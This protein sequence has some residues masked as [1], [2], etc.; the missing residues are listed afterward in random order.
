MRQISHSERERRGREEEREAVTI[1]LVQDSSP[2]KNLS[3]A[4]TRVK[5]S[6]HVNVC[7][8]HSRRA[9]LSLSLS[10]CT[11]DTDREQERVRLLSLFSGDRLGLGFC[12]VPKRLPELMT[13]ISFSV[14]DSFSVSSRDTNGEEG[15]TNNVMPKTLIIAPCLPSSPPRLSS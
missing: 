14:S 8:K 1:L 5:S 3:C 15:S 12:V 2:E 13:Q 9:G 10:L 6:V 4:E 7:H 11:G